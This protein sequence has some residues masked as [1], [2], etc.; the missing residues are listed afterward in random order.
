MAAL[1]QI[2]GVEVGFDGSLALAGVELAI[3]EERSAFSSGPT[4][5]GRPP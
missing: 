3:D 5:R 2:T 1:L 4:G